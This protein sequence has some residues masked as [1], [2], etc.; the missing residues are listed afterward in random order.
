MRPVLGVITGWAYPAGV[1]G[2]KCMLIDHGEVRIVVP[3][4]A[5]G[6]GVD[7]GIGLPAIES[8]HLLVGEWGSDVIGCHGV[9]SLKVRA[10]G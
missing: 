4:V 10:T 9:A 6:E 3:A 8:F 2:N 1:C 7:L 5:T